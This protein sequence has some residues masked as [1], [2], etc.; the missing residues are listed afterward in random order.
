MLSE[1]ATLDNREYG[2]LLDD[3]GYRVLRVRNRS[4]LTGPI[5]LARG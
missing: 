5:T 2:L 4:D 3:Q 1:E